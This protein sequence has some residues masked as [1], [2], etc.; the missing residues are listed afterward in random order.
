[1]GFFKD[2]YVA[3]TGVIPVKVISSSMIHL[4]FKYVASKRITFPQMSRPAAQPNYCV[5]PT[6][7]TLRKLSLK[8]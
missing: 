6:I 5:H 2:N 7:K 4:L 1:L 8:R 3:H